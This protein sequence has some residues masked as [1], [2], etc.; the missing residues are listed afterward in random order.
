M[1]EGQTESL[2]HEASGAGVSIEDGKVVLNSYIPQ[3]IFMARMLMTPSTA[4]WLADLL[5]RTA[6]ELDGDDK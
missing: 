6:D 2:S 3:K 4:R 5:N 1:I